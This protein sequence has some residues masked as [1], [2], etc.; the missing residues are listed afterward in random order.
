MWT[1]PGLKNTLNANP[2]DKAF[3]DM[4]KPLSYWT[5]VCVGHRSAFSSQSPNLCFVYCLEMPHTFSFRP[6]QT[7]LFYYY[8]LYPILW[9]CNCYWNI[10]L[11]FWDVFLLFNLMFRESLVKESWDKF[12]GYR[13]TRSALEADWTKSNRLLIKFQFSWL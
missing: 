6:A 4:M 3:R 7:Q 13:R 11:M 12:Y 8:L 9:T 5:S 1:L 2:F 10:F